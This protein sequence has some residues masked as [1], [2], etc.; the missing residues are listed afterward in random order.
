MINYFNLLGAPF[1]ENKI[2]KDRN[3]KIQRDQWGI[4]EEYLGGHGWH[5]YTLDSTDKTAHFEFIH[6]VNGRDIYAKGTLDAIVYLYEKIIAN[7]KGTVF[8]M[9]DVLKGV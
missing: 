4:P 6:N 3:P 7:V 1:S 8:T 9:I 2:I 5:T